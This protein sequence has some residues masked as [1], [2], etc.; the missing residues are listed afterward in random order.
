MSILDWIKIFENLSDSEREN[1]GL[2]CQIKNLEEW[3]ILFNE[4]DEANAMYILKEGIIEISRVIQW[5]KTILWDVK[6]EEILWEMALFWDSSKRM[7]TAVAQ[8]QCNMLVI[9]WFSIKELTKT[10][11]E[12]M[13][14]IKMIINDRM[15][16][17][18]NIK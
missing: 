6:A 9:L 16:S 4:Q 14:K 1:L 10:H 18:K 15:M 5:E 12:L 11:P 8:T 17:N 7:A 13:E 2:F 3:E